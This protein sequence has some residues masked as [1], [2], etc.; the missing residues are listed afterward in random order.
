MAIFGNG[1]KFRGVLAGL[2]KELGQF[3]FRFLQKFFQA[4]V[5]CRI[6]IQP[7][8]KSPGKLFRGFEPV[9]QFAVYV[10][11]NTLCFHIVLEDP[12]VNSPLKNVHF[13][14]E[15]FIKLRAESS[16]ISMKPP[17]SARTKRA[18]ARLRQAPN[19]DRR[20][21]LAE[22]CDNSATT[23][24]KTRDAGLATLPGGSRPKMLPVA[25]RRPGC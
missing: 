13:L 1:P 6:R 7:L 5:D 17:R 21:R 12:H 3:F 2:L 20:A 9:S 16:D 19:T 23:V 8:P 24:H 15:N 11:D 14:Y 4:L 18:P 25:G 22:Q 10:E